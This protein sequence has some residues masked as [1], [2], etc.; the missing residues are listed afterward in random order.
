MSIDLQPLATRGT[1]LQA[2][3]ERALQLAILDDPRELRHARLVGVEF[4]RRLVI[5][6]VDAH[7]VHRRDAL[8][9]QRLPYAKPPQKLDVAGAERIYPGIEAIGQ[10]RTRRGADQRHAC[11]AQG[12]R[13]ARADRASAHDDQIEL[14][15][16][17]NAAP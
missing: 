16:V 2:A 8:G 14:V 13:E 12:A 7:G 1:R 3:R 5:V 11:P 10:G 15:P 17:Y 4:E 6:A 9:R